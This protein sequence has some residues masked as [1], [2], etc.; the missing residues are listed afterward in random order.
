MMGTTNPANAAPGTIR[1]QCF[2]PHYSSPPRYCLLFVIFCC[3]IRGDFGIVP[4]RNVIHGSDAVESG[5]KEVD[6]FFT[7][8][9]LTFGYTHTQMIKVDS[10]AREKEVK[11]YQNPSLNTST[12]ISVTHR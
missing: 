11:F 3:Y 9:L 7:K 8:I 4:G 2:R 5:E 10:G 12:Q 1:F 6:N